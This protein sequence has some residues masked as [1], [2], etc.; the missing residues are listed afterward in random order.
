MGLSIHYN[1]SFKVG[2]SLP[3]MIEEVEEVA[4]V[5][6]W[7]YRVF[8]TEF[9]DP[10][11]RSEKYSDKIYGIHFTPPDCETVSISFLSNGKMSTAMHLEFYGNSDD[12]DYQEYLYTISVKTQYAGIQIHMLIIH[13]MKYL[14]NKYFGRFEMYDE[15]KYWETG[16]QKILEEI[17]GRYNL[18]MDRFATA[19]QTIPSNG[20]ENLEEYLLRIFEKVH[21][22]I[23]VKK[24][25]K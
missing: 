15:G 10:N 8:E 6:K 19:L 23:R 18:I 11:F 5:H 3:E 14:S 12:K 16:D 13:L 21:K 25:K 9:P 24:K 22:K 1:G 4:K 20:G 2:A 7:K 17:F